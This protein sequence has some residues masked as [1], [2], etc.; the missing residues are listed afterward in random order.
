MVELMV[1]R[2]HEMGCPRFPLSISFLSC[3]IYS[4]KLDILNYFGS[5]DK[6]Q[7]CKDFVIASDW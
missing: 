4:Q 2:P 3:N 7:L 1:P 6:G 5:K